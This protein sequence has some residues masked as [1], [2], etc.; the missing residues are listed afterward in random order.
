MKEKR[1]ITEWGLGFLVVVVIAWFFSGLGVV[2]SLKQPDS[3]HD[4][5]HHFTTTTW[6]AFISWLAPFVLVGLIALT[7]YWVRQGCPG[8]YKKVRIPVTEDLRKVK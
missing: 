8:L 4:G 3:N 6:W 1:E 2:V 7:S 5:G